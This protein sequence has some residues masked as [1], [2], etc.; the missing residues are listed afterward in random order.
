MPAEEI[1]NITVIFRV[2][3]SLSKSDLEYSLD[4]NIC[5]TRAMRPQIANAMSQIQE[6][7]AARPGPDEQ[8]AQLIQQDQQLAKILEEEM[9]QR[10][11]VSVLSCMHLQQAEEVKVAQSQ[12][13]RRL[14]ALVKQQWQAIE[15]LTSPQNP[16]RVSRAFPSCSESCLDSMRKEIFNLILGTMNMV[17]GAAVSHN[18]TVASAPRISQTSFEDMLGEE[19]NGTPRCQ[20]KHVTFMDTMRGCYFIYTPKKSGRG[21]LTIKNSKEKPPRGCQLA[22]GCPQILKNAE[23]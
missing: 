6:E 2:L 11:Q 14:L 13:I 1:N 9:T 22:C 4:R 3:Q 18:T 5:W 23:P 12:E 15:K 8:A 10:E 19:A 7:P 16:P 21:G 20:P 17:R